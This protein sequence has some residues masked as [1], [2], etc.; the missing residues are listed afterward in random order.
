MVCTIRQLCS[1]P[2]CNAPTL[3]LPYTRVF[4]LTGALV[5]QT[6]DHDSLQLG[7]NQILVNFS[8]SFQN[9][10][11]IKALDL[12]CT[13]GSI[14]TDWRTF[15]ITHT[16]YTLSTLIYQYIGS[17]TFG[18]HSQFSEGTLVI[19]SVWLVVVCILTRVQS[20]IKATHCTHQQ[21]DSGALPFY[22]FKLH[23]LKLVQ[24]LCLKKSTPWETSLRSNPIKDVLQVGVSTNALRALKFV[25]IRSNCDNCKLV[26]GDQITLV[27]AFSKR[28]NTGARRM[29]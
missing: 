19:H 2:A 5:E 6:V 27:Q 10:V 4:A 1:A 14:F 8:L 26:K 11:H 29:P 18:S 25:S 7:L 21:K 9:G 28:R 15:G 24:S 20:S 22:P 16:L 17:Y 12:R 3:I 23:L 13:S